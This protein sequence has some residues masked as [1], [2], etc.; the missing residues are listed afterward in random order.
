MS[1]VAEAA[2]GCESLDV[3]E[4]RADVA[5]P[6]LQLAQPRRV[7]HQ[8]TVGQPYELAV[9]RRVTAGAVRRDLG[10]AHQLRAG[11]A[12]EQRRLADT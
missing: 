2:L 9:S 10:G 11:E 12:V 3:V 5:F 4:R 7:D 1:A 8:R 6:E